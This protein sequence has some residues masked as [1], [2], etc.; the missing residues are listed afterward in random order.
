MVI[1]I[2]R[3]GVNRIWLPILLTPHVNEDQHDVQFLPRK[4]NFFKAP[5]VAKE[6]NLCPT[7]STSDGG[8]RVVILI[9][10]WEGLTP[11]DMASQTQDTNLGSG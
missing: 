8:D 10:M 6:V 2:N 7:L 3:L 1:T 11:W 9:P 5:E 4:Q